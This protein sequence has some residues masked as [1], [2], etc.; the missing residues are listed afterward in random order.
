MAHWTQCLPNM[1]MA[2][3]SIPSTAQTSP[4]IP[5]LRKWRQE[6]QELEVILSYMRESKTCLRHVGSWK[7]EEDKGWG[8][9]RRGWEEEGRRNEQRKKEK[10]LV[11]Q[12][13]PALFNS[14]TDTQQCSLNTSDY[15]DGM[16]GH[17]SSL[18][19]P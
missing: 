1:H 12:T 19:V 15:T 4:A 5:A 16:G 14:M 11:P 13:K 7:E 6:D 8:R 9:E 17:P 10:C 2:L 3:S 18:T